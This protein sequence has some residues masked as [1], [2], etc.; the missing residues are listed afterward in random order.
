MDYTTLK[1]R[2][3]E[4]YYFN[5]YLPGTLGSYESSVIFNYLLSLESIQENSTEEMNISEVWIDE[6]PTWYT[7]ELPN[8]FFIPRFSG[9]TDV[10][11][12]ERLIL[13]VEVGQNENTIINAVWSVIKKALIS[14]I[15]IQIIDKL[16]GVSAV[17]DDTNDLG[18]PETTAYWD[19]TSVWSSVFDVQ[20]TLFLVDISILNRGS[21]TDIT[22]WDYWIKSENYTKIEDMVKLYKP[23]GSTFEI[24]LN[25]PEDVESQTDIFSNT[26]IQWIGIHKV[27][28]TTIV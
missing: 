23:P 2:V 1:N 17:W 20:R 24:R 10:E 25:I 28:D 11:Y 9:E 13:L 5:S 3:F 19:D 7:S 8:L 12:L 27:S 16:E 4:K 26:L 18:A 22:T 6:N 21:E 14:K 15:Y